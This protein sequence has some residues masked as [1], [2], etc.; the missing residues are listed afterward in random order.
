MQHFCSLL[1]AAVVLQMLYVAVGLLSLPNLTNFHTADILSV[2]LSNITRTFAFCH[3]LCSEVKKK[4]R[5][6]GLGPCSKL[7]IP[8]SEKNAHIGHPYIQCSIQ[9]VSN[10]EIYRL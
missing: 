5:K 8:I 1:H 6:S 7:P 9:N 4:E 3:K 10:M 2:S